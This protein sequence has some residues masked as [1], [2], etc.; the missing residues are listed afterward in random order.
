MKKL[1]NILQSYRIA[2]GCLQDWRLDNNSGKD[3]IAKWQ[4]CICDFVSCTLYR[5]D[6]LTSLFH[7]MKL[8]CLSSLPYRKQ[9]RVNWSEIQRKTWTIFA[10]ETLLST[11][12]LVEIKEAHLW[13]F[14]YKTAT[15]WLF[16]AP[17][18]NESLFICLSIYYFFPAKIAY[19]YSKQLFF[20]Y[21][22]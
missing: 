11:L 1:N 8:S 5:N 9:V 16:L 18:W 7:H 15:N 19:K 2:P 13:N 22:D 21:C 20:I 10:L 3:S 12:Q 6:K 17:F 4:V 14:T